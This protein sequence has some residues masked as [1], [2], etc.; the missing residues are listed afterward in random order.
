MKRQSMI[1]RSPTSPV[2]KS[3]GPKIHAFK[4]CSSPFIINSPLIINNEFLP[5]ETM[6]NTA[7]NIEILNRFMRRLRRERTQYARQGS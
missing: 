5:E 7:R 4:R 3:L 6:I 1:W 2:G